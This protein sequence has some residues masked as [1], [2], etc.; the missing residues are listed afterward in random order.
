MMQL[1]EA[2]IATKGRVLGEDVTFTCVTN[3]SR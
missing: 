2:A 3:D 1:S